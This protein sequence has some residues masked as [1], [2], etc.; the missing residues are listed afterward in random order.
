VESHEN[1][2]GDPMSKVITLILASL[3]TASMSYAKCDGAEL[4]PAFSSE[5][6]GLQQYN[7]ET[8]GGG[9]VLMETFKLSSGTG[10]TIKN[11]GCDNLDRSVVLVEKFPKKSKYKAELTAAEVIKKVREQLS[12]LP[13][14]S[15]FTK[16]ALEV[17]TQQEAVFAKA[18]PVYEAGGTTYT[19]RNPNSSLSLVEIAT[20]RTASTTSAEMSIEPAKN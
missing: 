10:V 1:L 14:E 11:G 16:E 17:L 12:K 3:V 9:T 7:A 6:K 4:K 13:S 5:M 20:T 2:E 15:S 18:S 8:L 19:I